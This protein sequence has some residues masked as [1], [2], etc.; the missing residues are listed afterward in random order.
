MSD[1]PLLWG[2]QFQTCG[3][4]PTLPP[5]MKSLSF[6]LAVTSVSLKRFSLTPLFALGSGWSQMHS[7]SFFQPGQSFG[8]CRLDQKCQLQDEKKDKQSNGLLCI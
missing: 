4:I 8:N 5:C 1:V 7:C 6:S 2:E 3:V